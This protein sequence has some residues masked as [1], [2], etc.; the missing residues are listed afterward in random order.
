MSDSKVKLII[1]YT[2]TDCEPYNSDEECPETNEEY[3]C[4]VEISKEQ[5]KDISVIEDVKIF[6]PFKLYEDK[7]ETKNMYYYPNGI[8]RSITSYKFE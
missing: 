4:V 8:F 5:A 3:E 6:F 7:Y 2:L 1:Y